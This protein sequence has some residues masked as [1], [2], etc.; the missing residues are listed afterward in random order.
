MAV[1]HRKL[2]KDCI[3]GMIWHMDVPLPP[4]GQHKAGVIRPSR[5]H[6]VPFRE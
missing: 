1:D 3:R 2:L 5:R 4:S 6:Y